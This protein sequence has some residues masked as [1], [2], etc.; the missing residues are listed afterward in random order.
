MLLVSKFSFTNSQFSHLNTRSL[1]KGTES[2]SINCSCMSLCLHFGT[3]SKF[4]V[5]QYLHNNCTIFAKYI[6]N[7]CSMFNWCVDILVFRNVDVTNKYACKWC[8]LCAACQHVLSSDLYCN[9]FIYNFSSKTFL[10]SFHS[11]VSFVIFWIFTFVTNI[12]SLIFLMFKN[13]GRMKNYCFVVKMWR[14][15]NV[16]TSYTWGLFLCSLS[17]SSFFG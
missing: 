7:I 10:T 17:L 16:A 5:L 4:F 8:N 1:W 14:E 3:I 9:Y 2:N 11:C 15:S 6:A 13:V 12:F